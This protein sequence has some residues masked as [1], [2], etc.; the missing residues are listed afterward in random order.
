[1]GL[2]TN[3]LF[4]NI[5][6]LQGWNLLVHLNHRLTPSGYSLLYPYQGIFGVIIKKYLSLLRNP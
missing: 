6:P 2:N 4:R 3:T 1:M 5:Q